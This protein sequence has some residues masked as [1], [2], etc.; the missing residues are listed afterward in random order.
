MQNIIRKQA[1]VEIKP[2][3]GNP[4]LKPIEYDWN[5]NNKASVKSWPMPILA[6]SS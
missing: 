1:A 4:R 3:E 2:L 6:I 5:S